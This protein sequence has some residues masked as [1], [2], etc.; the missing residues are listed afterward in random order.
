MESNELPKEDKALIAQIDAR[1]KE[2][3]ENKINE[4]EKCLLNIHHWI[5]D[6]EAPLYKKNTIAPIEQVEGAT[7]YAK[8]IISIL[9]YITKDEQYPIIEETEE[10]YKIFTDE[11]G[12]QKI[13][14]A[15]FVLCQ[16][17]QPKEEV[18]ERFNISVHPFDDNINDNK[19]TIYYNDRELST[20]QAN[21][22][23]TQIKALLQTL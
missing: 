11:L 2:L 12:L 9:S 18:K 15:H 1:L 21:V 17:E 7:Q 19:I 22:L 23:V 10:H 5:P 8:A 3:Y 13:N 14:K 16:Q 4:I 20:Q 6:C